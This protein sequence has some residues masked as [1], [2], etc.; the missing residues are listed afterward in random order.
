M[1]LSMNDSS[2]F[3]CTVTRSFSLDVCVFFLF[4]WQLCSRA[5]TFGMIGSV[6]DRVVALLDEGLAEERGPDFSHAL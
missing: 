6:F 5:E 2:V 1:P 4:F 3:I